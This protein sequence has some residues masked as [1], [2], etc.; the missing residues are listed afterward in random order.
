MWHNGTPW[1]VK[2]AE[3]IIHHLPEQRDRWAYDY[4]VLGKGL[5]GVWKKTGNKRIF[6]YIKD[7]MD[8]FVDDNGRIRYYVLEDYNIDYINNGK[9]LI[10]LYKETGEPK[11]KKAIDLLREQLKSHPRTSEGGF[12]HKKIYP[13]QMWLDGLYMGSPFYAEYIQLYE[14]G[15]NFE[16][17]IKQFVLMNQYSRDPK[18]GL[19]YH[20]WDESRQQLW[21]DK[22]TGCSANF[23][24][25]SMG[26]FAMALVDVL[27]YIPEDHEGRNDVVE[28]LKNMVEALA[29]VQDTESGLWYQVL[30]QKDRDGNYLESSASSMFTYAMA[31]AVRK[32]Y[33]EPTYKTVAEKAMKGML[34]HFI[35][36]DDQGYLN[37]TDINNG[38]GLGGTPY[39]DGSYE[40]YVGE[41]KAVNNLLG[42]GAFIQ[43][44]VEI[45][46]H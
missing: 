40:Y 42:V 3:S 44:C 17:V 46:R 35:E 12:W 29:K 34:V 14:N 21:S 36:E 7:N 6:D 19:L 1:S 24:G 28:I 18:T 45:E 5:E 43:A 2:M 16:D 39:R 27:D 20:G 31:K 38:A 11:Y 30:D 22:E 15:D 4:G 25:R 10:F 23:W 37:L 8:H 13:Y 33:I 26:W 9:T 41:P 32:G